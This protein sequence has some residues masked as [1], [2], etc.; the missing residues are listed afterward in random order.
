M[1]IARGS[2]TNICICDS[3]YAVNM[4]GDI[5][6]P[7]FEL[8]ILT[9]EN[10]NLMIAAYSAKKPESLDFSSYFLVDDRDISFI[11]QRVKLH[12][13]KLILLDV[14]GRAAFILPSLFYSSRLILCAVTES[15]ADFAA[16]FADI[17][18]NIE[19]APSTEDKRKL[20]RMSSK[21][22]AELFE[23]TERLRSILPKNT[24]LPACGS[25]SLFLTL[26]EIS[27]SAAE[28]VGCEVKTENDGSIAEIENFDIS[29]FAAFVLCAAAYIKR[30]GT[31]RQGTILF[32]VENGK[33]LA[34]LNA[35]TLPNM[36]PFEFNVLQKLADEAEMYFYTFFENGIFVAE[37]AAQRPD[38]SKIGLK[39]ETELN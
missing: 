33:L 19:K 1:P 30:A 10:D 38:I 17:V 20:K 37:L 4:D 26:E 12:S 8:Y 35:E 31:A 27:K 13:D 2:L 5:M 14:G 24:I 36:K 15:R 39:D 29:F 22:S 18:G 16:S 7:H 21:R 25:Y 3:I 11:K 34:K 32:S 28:L 9:F 23:L 6:R